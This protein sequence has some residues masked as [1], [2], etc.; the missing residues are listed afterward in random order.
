MPDQRHNSISH[1]PELKATKPCL[2]LT[3]STSQNKGH[4]AHQTPK[5]RQY[6]G[7]MTQ[8]KRESAPSPEHDHKIPVTIH[9]S[10]ATL[11]WIDAI[12]RQLKVRSR[13]VIIEQLLQEIREQTTPSI[14]E[15]RWA[16]GNWPNPIG[17]VAR[18]LKLLLKPRP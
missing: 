10:P 4:S 14:R 3:L 6:Q 5:H 9:L 8:N 18:K 1:T 13:G 2:L 7:V 11:E 15:S 12:R 17:R 16:V